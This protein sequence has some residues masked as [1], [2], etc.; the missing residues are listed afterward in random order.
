MNN[1]LFFHIVPTGGISIILIGGVA[2]GSFD[3]LYLLM[4]RGC[5]H[6]P[7]PFLKGIFGAI[8]LDA[9]KV[10]QFQ[11]KVPE[12]GFRNGGVAGQLGAEL[13]ALAGK[14]SNV[15]IQVIPGSTFLLRGAGD[16]PVG[17]HKGGKR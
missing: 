2:D 4:G 10:D 16:D 6:G 17:S 1:A 5:F 9:R 3:P 11:Q 15:G 8:A 7:Q 12:G 13:P 14:S